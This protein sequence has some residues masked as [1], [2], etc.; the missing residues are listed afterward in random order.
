ME[1]LSWCFE[2]QMAR[3]ESECTAYAINTE[4]KMFMLKSGLTIYT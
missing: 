3:Y 4:F 2:N 1:H